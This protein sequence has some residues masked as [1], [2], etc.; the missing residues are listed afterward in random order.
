ME[1]DLAGDDLGR[2]SALLLSSPET[3]IIDDVSNS[4]SDPSSLV[5]VNASTSCV[6]CGISAVDSMEPL[7]AGLEPRFNVAPPGTNPRT[8]MSVDAIRRFDGSHE[9]VNG[10]H[11]VTA[12]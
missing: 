4:V 7:D 6:P 11:W 8:E 10:W 3:V 1:S 2:Q 5:L 12:D 9:M